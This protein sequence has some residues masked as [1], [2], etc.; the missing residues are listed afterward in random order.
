MPK[1]R[2]VAGG[3][4]AGARKLMESGRRLRKCIIRSF[5]PVSRS[6]IHHPRA[7]TYRFS[8]LFFVLRL[9]A[10]FLLFWLG[11]ASDHS[12]HTPT[13]T[14]F[15]YAELGQ[16]KIAQLRGSGQITGRDYRAI[17]PTSGCKG[18]NH[19]RTFRS[20]LSRAKRCFRTNQKN[21]CGHDQGDHS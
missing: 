4:K 20:I 19:L 1:S 21:Y 18:R 11:I 12:A 7:I 10:L 6:S 5:S 9:L 16:K 8:P 15:H 17:K 2:Q 14:L 3:K 13:T